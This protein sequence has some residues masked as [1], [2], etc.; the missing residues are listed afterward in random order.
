MKIELI[1]STLTKRVFDLIISVS[2]L[3]AIAP[4]WLVIAAMIRVDSKGA[5]FFRQERHGLNR[6]IFR[7]Y[8]FRTMVDGAQNSGTGLF[9][10]TDDP[11]ITRIGRRLRQWSIDETPQL[12]N[13]IRGEMSIV[14]PRPPVV[15]ELEV[16][17]N[18]PPDYLKRFSVLPGITGLA[19]TSGRNSLD[20]SEKARLDLCY[21]VDHKKFGLLLD[22]KIMLKT[23]LIVVSRG[24]VVETEVRDD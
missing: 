13:V 19:Q 2:A 5:V 23:I 22:S 6:K 12:I 4:F 11:R 17:K 21:I 7:I 1:S 16:E 10:Y 24:D 8:K 18:L 9:S 3:L 15:G 20:W 14:G